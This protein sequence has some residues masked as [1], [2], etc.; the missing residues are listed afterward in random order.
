M[1]TTT[2]LSATPA[3]HEL[4]A[5]AV[6][7]LVDG[8]AVIGHALTILRGAGHTAALVANRIT[9][10][11]L[12][13]AQLVTVNSTAWWHVYAIDGTPPVFTVGTAAEPANW[14]GCVES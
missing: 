2:V 12:V 11:Q 13:E 4:T 9:V 6:A 1:S 10:G 3:T 7:R 14:I 8:I 5:E